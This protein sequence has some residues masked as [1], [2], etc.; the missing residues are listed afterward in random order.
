MPP[1]MPIAAKAKNVM[2]RPKCSRRMGHM[3][4]IEKLVICIAKTE[5]PFAIPRI[6]IEDIS[7]KSSQVTGDNAPCWKQKKSAYPRAPDNYAAHQ[8][9]LT[10]SG[11]SNVTSPIANSLQV[12]P[13]CPVS[14]SGRRPKQLNSIMPTKVMITEIRP[15]AIVASSEALVPSPWPA[16]WLEHKT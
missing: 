7:D 16:A 4:A 3:K 8:D 1:A 5:M 15:L 14:N 6:C 13:I 9:D 10:V 12:Q 11:I 2:V